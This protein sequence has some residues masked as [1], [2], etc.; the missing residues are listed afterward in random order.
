M[1]V[2]YHRS[3]GKPNIIMNRN[4]WLKEIYVTRQ[5]FTRLFQ[6]CCFEIILHDLLHICFCKKCYFQWT[7]LI[8]W[9]HDNSSEI[10]LNSESEKPTLLMIIFSNIR[11]TLFELRSI[12]NSWEKECF[13]LNVWKTETI[14]TNSVW[15]DWRKCSKRSTNALKS[16]EFYSKEGETQI[17]YSDLKLEFHLETY[18]KS[19]FIVRI[20]FFLQL[21]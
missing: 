8:H 4:L 1:T 21:F 7:Y 9:I 17:L 16:N 3:C 11:W 10:I 20:F 18:L 13:R 2:S 5:T 14:E 12:P 15:I 6:S 19:T